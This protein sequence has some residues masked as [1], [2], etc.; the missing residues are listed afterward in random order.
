MGGE[1]NGRLLRNTECFAVGYSSWRCS[2]PEVARRP[3]NHNYHQLQ[4]LPP[5]QHARA[6]CAVATQQNMVYVLGKSHHAAL[7][8]FSQERGLHIVHEG[9][10]VR[11]L[12]DENDKLN[13]NKKTKPDG[14]LT[15]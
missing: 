12:F 15:E 14:S 5:M 9:L 8:M 11:N 10:P 7:E 4:V 2:I 13:K 6:Y 3:N 1:S